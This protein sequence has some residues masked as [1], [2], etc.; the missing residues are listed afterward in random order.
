ML[1]RARLEWSERQFLKDK[2]LKGKKKKVIKITNGL[3]QYVVKVKI[4]AET[5][6][7]Q[8]IKIVRKESINT[9]KCNITTR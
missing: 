9:N 6:D 5:H 8:N 4:N 1:C 2:T 3:I 7:A